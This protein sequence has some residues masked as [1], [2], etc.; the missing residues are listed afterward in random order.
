MYLNKLNHKHFTYRV[1]P[2]YLYSFNNGIYFRKNSPFVKAFDEKIS[3]LKAAG[4]IEFW[5]S[6]YLDILYLNVKVSSKAPRKLNIEQLEGGFRLWIYGCLASF[7]TFAIE[8]VY[9][10]CRRRMKGKM[11]KIF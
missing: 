10:N 4:L 8:N 6:K 9:S 5:V 1:L 3:L 7:I 2:D 11:N